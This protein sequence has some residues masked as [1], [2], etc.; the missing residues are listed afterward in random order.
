MHPVPW[1]L[2]SVAKLIALACILRGGQPRKYSCLRQTLSSFECLIAGESSSSPTE[3]E[4]MSACVSC[5]ENERH[6]KS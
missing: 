5:L 4:R 2:V 3:R 1:G 6:M